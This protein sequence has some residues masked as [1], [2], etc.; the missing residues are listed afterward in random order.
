MG[1]VKFTFTPNM[2]KMFSIGKSDDPQPSE[3]SA[4]NIVPF[5]FSPLKGCNNQTCA[6]S[7][8]TLS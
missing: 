2:A 6:F 4:S 3:T 7:S 8:M 1:F 5:I